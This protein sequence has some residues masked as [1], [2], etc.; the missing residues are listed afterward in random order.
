MSSAAD[1]LLSLIEYVDDVGQLEVFIEAKN[2]QRIMHA[3]GHDD[4][5]MRRMIAAGETPGTMLLG[6]FKSGRT[7]AEMMALIPAEDRVV[8]PAKKSPHSSARSSTKTLE[9]PEI[10]SPGAFVLVALGGIFGAVAVKLPAVGLIL[11]Q[12]WQVAFGVLALTGAVGGFML[13]A[14]ARI[15]GVII[16]ALAS[17]LATYASYRYIIWMAGTERES[18]FLVEPVL[19]NMVVVLLIFGVPMRL[20]SKTQ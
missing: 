12:Y 3:A 14:R 13:L 17:P 7:A 18:L 20:W 2:L 8:Q 5:A 1:T 10:Q 16:G 15:A 4:A 11:L 19:V 9:G 6:V